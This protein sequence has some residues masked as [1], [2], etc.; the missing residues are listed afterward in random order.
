MKK[1]L[2]KILTY[3]LIVIAA[4][5][6]PILHNRYMQKPIEV[7]TPLTTYTIVWGE[8]SGYTT[9]DFYNKVR[10]C[11]ES[12]IRHIEIFLMSPGGLAFDCFGAVDVME[13]AK[14]EGIT[15]TVKAY[16]LVASAAVPVF[17]AGDERI[18]GPNTIFMLH[19]PEK[20]SYLDENDLELFNLVE[21]LY[22]SI[23]AKYCDLTYDEVDKLCND[24]TWFTAEQAKRYGMADE[25]R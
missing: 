14:A 5:A 9:T 20:P 24:F 17:V 3:S 2:L 15:F 10:I 7:S 11:Q 19:K 21:R 4:F 13:Q 25:V 6:A 18:A 22:I 23:V 8:M 16:G 1:R 12:G